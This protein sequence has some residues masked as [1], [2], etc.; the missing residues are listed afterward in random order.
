MASNYLQIYTCTFFVDKKQNKTKETVKNI[1]QITKPQ[2]S[3][4]FS[5]Y[6]KLINS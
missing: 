4:P 6:A 3:I 2:V 1:Y 5:L